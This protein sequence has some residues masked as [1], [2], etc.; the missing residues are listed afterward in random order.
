MKTTAPAHPKRRTHTFKDVIAP[1]DF[2]AGDGELVGDPD[3]LVESVPPCGLS[4]GTVVLALEAADM[5][6]A[7]V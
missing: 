6:S 1:A 3:E 4:V 5:Y 7:R 2:T